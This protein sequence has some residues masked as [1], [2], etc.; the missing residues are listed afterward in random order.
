MINYASK[1]AIVFVL[2]QMRLA[3]L[4]LQNATVTYS[5]PLVEL[6]PEFEIDL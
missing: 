6:S 5:N 1:R 3:L 2:L 4:L